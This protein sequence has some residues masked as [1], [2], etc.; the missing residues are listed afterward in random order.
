MLRIG[1]LVWQE[2]PSIISDFLRLCGG[3]PSD[4]KLGVDSPISGILASLA[5]I[6]LKFIF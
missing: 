1:L 5:T 3:V 2:I 6:C 4:K